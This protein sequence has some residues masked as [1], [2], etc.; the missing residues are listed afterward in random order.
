M[1]V[2]AKD[3]AGQR[4]IKRRAAP[5]LFSHRTRHVQMNG[6]LVDSETLVVTFA[7]RAT[8]AGAIW[9]RVPLQKLGHSVLCFVDFADAWFPSA[10]MAELKETIAPKLAR[11]RRVVTY[12]HSM[13]GYGALKYGSLFQAA[14]SVGL[15]PAWSVAPQDIGM[16]DRRRPRLYYRPELHDGMAIRQAD[17]ADE[18]IVVF[19]PLHREDSAHLAAMERAGCRVRRA[20]NYFVGHDLLSPCLDGGQAS[21]FVR[22]IA[23]GAGVQGLRSTIR[24][25]RGL[26]SRYVSTALA[27]TYDADRRTVTRHIA[28]RYAMPLAS[29]PT[30]REVLVKQG[31]SVPELPAPQNW[32]E[33]FMSGMAGEAVATADGQ[34]FQTFTEK[35]AILRRWLAVHSDVGAFEKLAEFIAFILKED[36]WRG[37]EYTSFATAVL[38]GGKTQA[39]Y[40]ALVPLLDRAGAGKHNTEK[41]MMIVITA[42]LM[43]HGETHIPSSVFTST[44]FLEAERTDLLVLPPKKG[45]FV[46]SLALEL[47]AGALRI[48]FDVEADAEDLKRLL[49]DVLQKSGH[50]IRSLLQSVLDF[51]AAPGW[52]RRRGGWPAITVRVPKQRK[53]KEPRVNIILKSDG[54]GAGDIIRFHGVHITRV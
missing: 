53:Q 30:V 51:V 5:D 26:S 18:A 54:S 9:G 35:P 36:R 33:R 31:Y 14:R 16:F 24:A 49:P 6:H 3:P 20:Y 15:G 44:Y 27:S 13:G 52:G 29:Q 11:Y 23:N 7:P 1:M 34:P 32:L 43:L 19:D 42:D 4:P 39:H 22:E 50:S 12:G 21:A 38:R 46:R 28:E 47:P 2:A 17:L 10:D 25:S 48:T 40:A 8:E 37:D 41:R 45:E